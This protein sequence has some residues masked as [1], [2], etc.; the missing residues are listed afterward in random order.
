VYPVHRLAGVMRGVGDTGQLQQR[1]QRVSHGTGPYRV[2][3]GRGGTPRCLM[4]AP[5]APLGGLD[6]YACRRLV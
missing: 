5:Q 2:T 6:L 4:C 3:T 1:R